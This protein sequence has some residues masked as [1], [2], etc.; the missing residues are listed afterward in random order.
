M[1]SCAESVQIAHHCRLC[2]K[3]F[4]H[5]CSRYRLALPSLSDVTKY[6]PKK[7]DAKAEDS[8]VDG[9]ADEKE[10]EKKVVD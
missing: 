10:K 5:G 8:V 7:P 2:G 1:L 6:V 3:I 4:C 9:S